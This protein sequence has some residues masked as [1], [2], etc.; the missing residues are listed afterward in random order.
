MFDM[1]EDDICIK[2]KV[3]NIKKWNKM[4]EIIRKFKY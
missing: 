1:D 4:R 3:K 2:I